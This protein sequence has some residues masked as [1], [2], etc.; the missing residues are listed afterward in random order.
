MQSGELNLSL[1]DK[2]KVLKLL[3]NF[4]IDF[5][6]LGWPGASKAVDSF[7]EAA[8]KQKI[9]AKTAA[10]GSPARIGVS[11][12][13]DKGLTSLINAKT[14]ICTIFGKTDPDHVRL[15]LN[16]TPEENLETISKSTEFLSKK[17]EV[18][19]DA[20]HFFDGYLKN[21]KYAL[22]TLRA[23]NKA[24]ATKLIL[25][26]TNGGTLPGKILSIVKAVSKELPRAKLGIHTH[27]DSGLAV[28]NSIIASKY[29]SQIQV[30]VN[31]VGERTG[32]ADLCQ[33][34]PILSLKQNQSLNC[35]LESLTELSSKFNSICNLPLNPSRPFVG[36]S[37]FA[38]KGGIHVDAVTKG[39][40]YEHIHPKKVGNKRRVVLSGLSGRSTVKHILKEFNINVEKS[41]ERVRKFLKDVESL[42]KSG[43][44]ISDIAAEKKLLVQ[45][46]FFGKKEFFQ[47]KRWKIVTEK[48]T[49]EFSECVIVGLVD[50]KMRSVVASLENKGPVAASY[51]ALR[52]LIFTKYKCAKKVKLENYFVKIANLKREDSTVRVK[53][54]FTDGKTHWTNVG[55]SSNI[56]EASLEAIIKGFSYHLLK[57]F[58]SGGLR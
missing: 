17:R 13:M 30:T 34:A 51:K 47:V 23:A 46:H 35:N 11:P 2:I 57:E 58:E 37:A 28:A 26:D 44:Q 20:E 55:V 43:Y 4:G 53:I 22:E 31:G 54:D 21:K 33:I 50:G 7:F 1:S 6:E 24:G 15:Q 19:Y 36:R 38:H 39:A 5:I 14:D 8:K 16:A 27:N 48:K 52:D 18:F 12:R 3:D 32:N 25:C 49:G 10:F 40:S 42:E 45:K 29:L 9:S 56:L 41:D